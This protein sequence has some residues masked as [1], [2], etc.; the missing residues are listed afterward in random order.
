MSKARQTR[1]YRIHNRSTQERTVIVEHP[2]TASYKVVGP[3]KPS[4]QSREAY[5]FEVKVPAGKK[6]S[7]EVV[8]ESDQVDRMALGSYEES[9][10]RQLLAATGADAKVKAVVEKALELKG[11]LTGV[12]RALARRQGQLQEIARDQDRLRANLKEMPATA[13]AYKRY[14]DKFDRQETEIERLQGEVRELQDVEARQR[15]EYEAYWARVEIGPTPARSVEGVAPV[16]PPPPPV[17]RGV[18]VP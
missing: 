4:E 15:Q 16:Q 9:S 7:L 8:E 18:S 13:A 12:Q 5:R 2:I 1:T 17:V 6:A 10:L 3:V 14:L 11:K